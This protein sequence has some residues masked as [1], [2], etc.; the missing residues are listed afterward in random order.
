[1]LSSSQYGKFIIFS[2]ACFLLLVLAF[3]QPTLSQSS[4][5][6]IG[7][8]GDSSTDEYRGTDNRGGLYASTT[9]NWMEQLV[10]RGS[11][12]AGRW[13]PWVEP[14]RTGYEYNWARSASTIQEMVIQGQHTRLAAQIRSGLV[15]LAMVYAGN[16]DFAP[17][18]VNGLYQRIYQ[19]SLS[20]ML[21]EGALN[22]LMRDYRA[23]VDTLLG[24]GQIPI[25]VTTIGDWNLSP[26]ASG[27]PD[28]IRRQWVTGAINYVNS[29]IIRLANTHGLGIINSAEFTARLLEQS[30]GGVLTLGGVN[31]TLF[32]AGDKPH[33]GILGDQIHSG[34]ILSGLTANRYLE[35]VNQFVEPDIPL[36]SDVEILANAGLTP[37]IPTATPTP[38]LTPTPTPITPTSPANAAPAPNYFTIPTL[39]LTWNRVSE[40]RGYELQISGDEGFSSLITV[41]NPLPLEPLS[42]TTSTLPNGTYY[43]KVRAI[44]NTG[45]VGA[46]S[47]VE[48]FVVS[49]EG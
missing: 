9:F 30:P 48:M 28:P 15:D 11:I 12:D 17:F 7:F 44:T 1:M 3:Q 43:W 37:I 34:T 38:T 18:L 29:G 10:K 5:L 35:T 46:W 2:A 36:L 24:A 49:A 22:G 16:H 31:I 42:Y 6:R 21:L 32:A 26:S 25:I 20:G 19:G 33:N 45:E 4:T 13:G 27:F 23:M 40:A 8:M 47:K 14:R 41:P 39:T